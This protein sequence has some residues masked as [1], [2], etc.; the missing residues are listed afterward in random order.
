MT[1]R[2]A[3][4]DRDVD[5]AVAS[6]DELE[7]LDGAP[8]AHGGARAAGEHRAPLGGVRRL[9]QVADQVDAAKLAVKL[10][11][12]DAVADRPVAQ[13]ERAELAAR[14]VALLPRGYVGDPRLHVQ[15]PTI[16]LTCRTLVE[17]CTTVV[18]YAAMVWGRRGLVEL[19]TRGD[20]GTC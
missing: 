8:V 6:L 3:A 17:F 7:H 11:A 5:V 16:P 9:G 18:Q 13:A 15:N 10:P 19:C 14:D 4:G 1:A 20:V 2:A 12:L